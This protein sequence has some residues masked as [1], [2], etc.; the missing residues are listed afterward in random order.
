MLSP[1][2]AAKKTI[3]RIR[4]TLMLFSGLPAKAPAVNN[5]ES[6][7][8]NGITTKPVSMKIIKKIIP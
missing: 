6:P 5:K 8:R 3:N 7:G 1:I 4:C 2:M